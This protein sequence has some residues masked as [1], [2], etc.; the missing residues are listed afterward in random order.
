MICSTPLST[1]VQVTDDKSPTVKVLQASR[2][3]L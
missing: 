2:Y 1:V 3:S